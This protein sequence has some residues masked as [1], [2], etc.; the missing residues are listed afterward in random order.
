MVKDVRAPG[1]R[2]KW[3]Q[4]VPVLYDWWGPVRAEHG[5][6]S[7]QYVYI[8]EQTDGT[9]PNT[10]LLAN[11]A[12]SWELGGEGFWEG[13][14]EQRGGWGWFRGSTRRSGLVGAEVADNDAVAPSLLADFEE[15]DPSALVGV[16]K[17]V[18]HPGEVNRIRELPQF[19]QILATHTDARD[20][21]IW[22]MES[23]DDRRASKGDGA[24]SD[25]PSVP[26][27]VLRGHT[28]VAQF[29]LATAAS[30]PFVLS[31]GTDRHVV[32]W[33][34]QDHVS[35]ASTDD[36]SELAAPVLHC[37]ETF[38]GHR[39][40]V[41]DVQF[42][43]SDARLFCSVG[44]DYCL[45]L[46]DTR[47]GTTPVNKACKRA[48]KGRTRWVAG[49]AVGG[50]GGEWG[51]EE[52]DIPP[53]PLFTTAQIPLTSLPTTI[54]L[55]LSVSLP[56]LPP[57]LPFSQVER[58]H[59]ADLHCVDWSRL[60]DNYVLT[61]SADHSVRLF[62]RRK[63]PTAGHCTPVHTFKHHLD[64]V[65]CVQWH[66]S[67]RGVFG[68]AGD[69]GLIQVTDASHIMGAT[70]DKAGGGGAQGRQMNMFQH[71]GHREKVCEFH[72][73]PH[74]PWTVVSTSIDSGRIGGGT[75]QV[76]RM[77]DLF[78]LPEEAAQKK[79]EGMIGSTP[80]KK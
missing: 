75:L 36:S 1:F 28:D 37:R 12:V 5:A 25:K 9:A 54:P 68:S 6:Y 22:N 17:A 31:G 41:E 29:A 60:D 16:L 24:A 7:E 52:Q 40:T 53:L 23:Q 2:E 47:H 72:W 39:A 35:K 57:L 77:H 78:H 42:S 56:S 4:D 27:L 48:R 76:W 79:L 43:P 44:D 50:G 58:A 20:V 61:G 13:G 3:R 14:V 49:C 80:S 71:L 32:L 64:A 69:D 15:D 67:A 10:L 19:P 11:V 66:P 55:L 34:L 33:G 38:T 62:D 74:R 45:L 30:D 59:N 21:F 70:G 63:L 51:E 73:N 18:Q 8:S 26:D 46:W 65:T